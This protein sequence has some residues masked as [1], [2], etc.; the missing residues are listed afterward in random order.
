MTVSTIPSYLTRCVVVTEREVEPGSKHGHKQGQH[1]NS[2]EMLLSSFVHICFNIIKDL[3]LFFF[4]V[5]K[6]KL[7]CLTLKHILLLLINI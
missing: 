4:F 3:L 5:C 7:E 1:S 6:T 2:A